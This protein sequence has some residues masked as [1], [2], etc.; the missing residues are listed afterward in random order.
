MNKTQGMQRARKLKNR[1]KEKRGGQQRHED[2]LDKTDSQ[3]MANLLP[4]Y[5]EY[6]SIRNYSQ[7]T[8]RARGEYLHTALHWLQQR[9]IF[10]AEKV[11]R[12]ILE[13]YQRHLYRI[14]KKNDQ[15]LSFS[16][17]HNH[18]SALK[19][20]FKW[21][22]RQNYLLS[23][24]AS[25]LEMPRAEYRLPKA[26]LT[27]EQ[28]ETVLMQPDITDALGIRD[29]AILETF[30]STGLRRNELVSLCVDDLDVERRALMIRQGKG[31]K[32]RYLPIGK[33]ALSW[34]EK[35]CS[36]VRS[37]LL[38][39]QY[40]KTLFISSYGEAINCDVLSRLVKRYIDKAELG[41]SGSCH[42]F[43]HSMATH[44]LENGA[45]IR[46]VQ[47]MLGHAQLETTQIYTHVSIKKLQQVHELTHPANNQ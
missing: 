43:R 21:L 8:I 37:Q 34:I 47:A 46:F 2:C 29:R 42:L 12:P 41:K 22:C 44:M 9:S 16:T 19:Q 15:P 20:F 11:T 24:P 33:R 40:E 36:E 28:V 7:R 17:Q 4:L 35:Y 1:P 5:R 3:N 45:D 31:K 27:P 39:A 10:R 6:L 14:R 13:S 25:E 26:V 30:Y 38:I 18:I 32:D 23:N